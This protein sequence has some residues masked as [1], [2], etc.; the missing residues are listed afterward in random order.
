[1][2]T[3]EDFLS[4][5]WNLY[6]LQV[7]SCAMMFYIIINSMSLFAMCMVAMCVSV[8][9]ICQRLLGIRFGMIFYELNKDR[10]EDIIKEFRELEKINKEKK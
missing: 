6:G 3:T 7:V 4:N 5:Q 1:M 2:K 9:A 10:L 8:V